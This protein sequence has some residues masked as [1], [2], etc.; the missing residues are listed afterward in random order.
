[1]TL[2]NKKILINND[3][4]VEWVFDNTN[5]KSENYSIINN[6]LDG[7]KN[8]ISTSNLNNLNNNL[9]YIDKVT[10]KLSN[11]NNQD[12]IKIQNFS[13]SLIT[14]D[15]VRIYFSSEWD[16]NSYYGFYL[17]IYAKNYDNKLNYNFS[18]FFFTT[19]NN[20]LQFYNYITPFLYNEKY[21]G[22][23]IEI[24][25]PSIDE[26][27][28]QRTITG[29]FNKATDF[30]INKNLTNGEGISEL[31]P[32]FINFAY[33][34]SIQELLTDKYY[35]INDVKNLS[36][37]KKPEYVTLGV[38][39]EESNQGDYFEIYGIYNGSNENMDNFVNDLIIRGSRI[40]IEYEISVY[41]ESILTQ[42]QTYKITQNF[43]NKI[44]YRPVLKFTNTTA[45][46]DVT[47]RVIDIVNSSIIERNS[48]IGL[49]KNVNKYGRKLSSINLESNTI[50]KPKIYN[51]KPNNITVNNTKN[52]ITSNNIIK[53]PYPM[54]VDKYKI[55]VSNNN[56]NI[57]TDYQTNGKLRIMITSFD[58]VINFNI[59]KNISTLRNKQTKIDTYNLS[60]LLNNGR[61][62]LVFKSDDEQLEKDIFQEANNNFPNGVVYYKLS[63]NDNKILKRI[64]SKGFDNFYLIIDGNGNK[65]QLYSGKF[66]FYENAK[67]V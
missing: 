29:S 52:D 67:F 57:S 19:D 2:I 63:Q 27:S 22:K 33:I 14:F 38:N 34:T 42:T 10:N 59:A 43:T 47:M 11:I 4:L 37:N 16:F 46:I 8:Y 48:S 18:N 53:V 39:I 17:S 49:T 28:K 56:N 66:I 13:T 21:W 40:N 44:E 32:I 60:N 1:M 65:T 62:L 64:Y 50:I 20:P 6:L 51:L 55:L 61:L 36:I 58:N 25:I 15:K 9:I 23:Y 7:S 54:L 45:L 41:E 24:E 3:V 5:I 30:T 31:S 26:V 35:Y 12:F